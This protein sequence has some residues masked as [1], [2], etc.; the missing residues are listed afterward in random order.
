MNLVIS[1][2]IYMRWLI[3]KHLFTD[4]D[5]GTEVLKIDFDIPSLQD[6]DTG[7]GKGLNT[8]P[9]PSQGQPL[10]SESPTH[11]ETIS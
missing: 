3:A 4:E 7:L 9:H 6:K 10:G 1:I 5:T 11:L 2:N 8:S